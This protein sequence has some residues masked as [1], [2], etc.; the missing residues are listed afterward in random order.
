VLIVEPSYLLRRGRITIPVATILPAPLT[1]EDIQP[2]NRTTL[3]SRLG[4]GS[5]IKI[6]GERHG[7]IFLRS[8]ISLLFEVADALKDGTDHEREGDGGVFEDL[9]EAASF[10]WRNELAPTNGFGV[11]AAAETAPV[12]RL[13]A[14]ADTVEVALERKIFVAAAGHEL[15]VDAEL[16]GPVA[17]N[18]TAD[19]EDAHFLCG[20]HGVRES[21]EVFEGIEAENR[22]LFFPAGVLIE[23]EVEAKF[24]IGESG[25][26]NGDVVFESR[27]EDAAALGVLCEEFADA[28]VK[29]PAT[30]DFVGIPLVE[31]AV[32]DFFD[33]I[34][35]GLGLE[36]VVDAVVAGEKEFLVVHL[37][38][39]VAEVRAARS[40]DE[41]VSH[42]SAG[43]D[44]SFDDAGLD[45][46]AEDE[47]HLADGE[48]A[49]ES[50][51][52][53]AIFVAG[54]G[55]EDVGGVT[56]LPGSVGGV[57]HGAYKIVDSFDFGEIERVD[58]AE[59]VFDGIVENA[60]GDGLAGVFG[61]R[62]S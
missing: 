49:G 55:F 48:S 6:V 56:D 21:F 31:D 43:G 16:L 1:L 24:R 33:V 14:D 37:G 15:G 32:D 11:G 17:R 27:P 3:N 5:F 29:F 52:D 19:G 18:T 57:A 25:N 9:G 41:A 46:V 36:G 45:E 10:F 8:W 50:H 58:G 40:F 35:I 38:G 62:V 2:R 28:P 12:N 61:H 4:S 30:D 44:D 54:H 47:T 22:A 7:T 39:I 42:E 20:H 13:G 60:S 34:E 53:E 23:S 26:K 59:L 51:D